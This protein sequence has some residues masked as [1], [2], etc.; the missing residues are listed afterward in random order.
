MPVTMTGRKGRTIV[1]ATRQCEKDTAM[2][3]KYVQVYAVNHKL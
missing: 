2:Y 3:V 1:E